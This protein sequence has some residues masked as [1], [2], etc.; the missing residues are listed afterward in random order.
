MDPRDIAVDVVGGVVRLEGEVERRSEAESL[1][2]VTR[3]V[4]GVVA[5]EDRL[6][7]RFDNRTA[8]RAMIPRF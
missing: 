6:R 2:A 5:V 3:G 4:E 1:V 7:W 8:D